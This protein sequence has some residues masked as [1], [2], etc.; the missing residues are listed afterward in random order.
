VAVYGRMCGCV[1]YVGGGR[2]D[3]D[4]V[5]GEAVSLPFFLAHVSICLSESVDN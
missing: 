4:G 1:I 5:S 3:H 2:E